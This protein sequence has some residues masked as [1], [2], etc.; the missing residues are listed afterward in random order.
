M[1]TILGGKKSFNVYIKNSKS[2]DATLNIVRPTN[3]VSLN[4]TIAI[5]SDIVSTARR[6]TMT[7]LT[8]KDGDTLA[9]L[10]ALRLYQIFYT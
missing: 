6:A 9:T 10:D 4:E 7:L 3:Y 2:F 8:A 5:T 1:T